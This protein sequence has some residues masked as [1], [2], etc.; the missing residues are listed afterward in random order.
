MPAINVF[1]DTNI[2]LNFYS[3]SEDKSSHLENLTKLVGPDQII[4]HLPKQVEDEFWRNRESKIYTVV[5]EFNKAKPAASIPNHMREMDTA[6]QYKAALD[7][8]AA[9]QKKLVGNVLGLAALEDLE[10]DHRIRALFAAS[11]KHDDCEMALSRAITRMH[12]GNPPGK[13][14]NIGDR[15]NWETLLSTLPN[16][17]LHVVTNDGD[18]TTPL[19]PIGKQ[20]RPMPFLVKEWAAKAPGRN[21]Y[22]YSS[23][24]SLL[25][26]YKNLVDQPEE[27]QSQVGLVPNQVA[28]PAEQNPVAEEVAPVVDPQVELAKQVAIEK[29]VTSE[30]F[31]KTHQAITDL[32]AHIPLITVE[33]ANKLFEAA[34]A[35][36]QIS[37]IINDQDVRTFYVTVLNKHFLDADSDL[38]NVMI[39][40]L[41]LEANED[42]EGDD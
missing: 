37:R 14:G 7:T 2:L 11:V 6:I 8:A 20:P 28:Q 10:V 40:L 42:P 35:N 27:V 41:G 36:N 19:Q 30:S 34:T 22:V 13:P 1:I 17:D 39:E 15:Y 32:T 31:Q 25:S 3:F 4:V 33:D 26:Y 23:I 24:Q 18:F 9:A 12:K 16:E 21:L 38:V 29:L 5:T